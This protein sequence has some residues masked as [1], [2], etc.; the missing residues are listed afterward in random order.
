L[1]F[2]VYALGL[3]VKELALRPASPM[4]WLWTFFVLLGF[5]TVNFNWATGIFSFFS[6][7]GLGSAFELGTFPAVKFSLSTYQ[8]LIITLSV[9]LGAILFLLKHKMFVPRP[10]LAN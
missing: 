2:Y 6:D 10:A 1:L 4:T 8:P 3:S 9:P 5:G 7:S